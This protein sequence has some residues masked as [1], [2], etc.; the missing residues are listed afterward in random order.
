MG[1]IFDAHTTR[2]YPFFNLDGGSGHPFCDAHSLRSVCDRGCAN[3]DA[4]ALTHRD[5]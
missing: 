4:I 5:E 3:V 1:R 2:W